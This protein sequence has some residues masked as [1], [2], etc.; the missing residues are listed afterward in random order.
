MA[1]W[2][3]RSVSGLR[4]VAQRTGRSAKT[5]FACCCGEEVPARAGP[6]ARRP[7]GFRWRER[8]AG[9]SGIGAGRRLRAIAAEIG[10][11]PSTRCLRRRSTSAAAGSATRPGRLMAAPT[12]KHAGLRP[13]SWPALL[14]SPANGKRQNPLEQLWSLPRRPRSARLRP[15]RRYGDAGKP[16]DEVVEPLCPRPWGSSQRTC[17]GA[18]QR[19]RPCTALVERHLRQ[20]GRHPRTPS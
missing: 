1:A 9:H 20:Q 2:W 17:G 3:Q 18:C 4:V 16:R 7:P 10:R 14:A 15:Q 11:A 12:T 13:P 5:P 19:T 6:C 8:R